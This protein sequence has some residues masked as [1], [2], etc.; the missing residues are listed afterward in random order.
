MEIAG[1][2]IDDD[3]DGVIDNA[4]SDECSSESKFTGVTAVDAAQAMDLCQFT[5]ADPPKAQKIWGVIDA[6][7]TLADGSVPSAADLA[8]FQNSQAAVFTEFGTGGVVPRHGP[9]LVGI[10]SGMM[11][12]A[13]DPGFVVPV[14]GMAFASSIAFPAAGPL[15]T[16]LNA[17]GGQLLPGHCGTTT[18]PVGSGAND[19]IVLHLVIRV[20]T[21]ALGLSY[22]FRFFSAE[23]ETYQC[24]N[25]ND[26]YLA[27]LTSGAPAIPADHN[28][29]FDAMNNPVSVNNGFFQDCAGNGKNCGSCPFGTDALAGT[30]FDQVSGGATEW[31]TTDAPVVPG[32][33]ITLDIMVFDVSDHILDTS[34]L[35]DNFRWDL[36]PVV[37]GTYN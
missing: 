6:R 20:P 3:C 26:Y 5:T 21:N 18:C 36:N 22:N 24:T 23:Y 28:I 30:G 4:T 29:S 8:N 37:L 16:F 14:P 11:R 13:A 32:E 15:G 7:F 27:L 33:T 31:L 1:N 19:S 17:H 34:V 35:L 10:S 25:F 9:T 12:G 2:G